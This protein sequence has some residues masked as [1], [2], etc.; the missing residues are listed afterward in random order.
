MKGHERDAKLDM[1]DGRANSGPLSII[2]LSNGNVL[3]YTFHFGQ[4]Y[5]V[6]YDQFTKL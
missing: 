2:P 3:M 6:F 4:E 5:L 1:I